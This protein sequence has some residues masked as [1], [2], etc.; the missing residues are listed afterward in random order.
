[1][2]SVCFSRKDVRLPVNMQRSMAAEAEGKKIEVLF[3]IRISFFFQLLVRL[4]QKS[5]LL[6][7]NKKRR[8]R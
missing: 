1:M 4:V 5:S 3:S 2:I 8:D 6:K 7:V